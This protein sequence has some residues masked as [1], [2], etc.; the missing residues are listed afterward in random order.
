MINGRRVIGALFAILLPVGVGWILI[1]PFPTGV[2][3]CS[4]EGAVFGELGI[5]A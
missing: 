5:C 3:Y 4:G 1:P 2:G